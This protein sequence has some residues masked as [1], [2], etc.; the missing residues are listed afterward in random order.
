LKFRTACDKMFF[1]RVAEWPIASVLKTEG[2]QGSGGSNPSSSVISLIAK[3]SLS[4]QIKDSSYEWCPDRYFMTQKGITF[5]W[6]MYSQ[7]AA[8]AITINKR[9]LQNLKV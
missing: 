2:P 4:S 5:C 8:T 1:G 9:V 7:A 6:E 3:K